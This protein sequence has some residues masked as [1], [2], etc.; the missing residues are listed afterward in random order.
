MLNNI[1]FQLNFICSADRDKLR[2][3]T[4]EKAYLA[5]L[6]SAFKFRKLVNPFTEIACRP[7]KLNLKL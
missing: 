3:H 7:E 1:L 6:W 5:P 4:S 2:N